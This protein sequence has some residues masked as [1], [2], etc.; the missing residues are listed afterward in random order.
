LQQSIQMKNETEKQ[1]LKKT[2]KPEKQYHF[3]NKVANISSI[4][5]TKKTA[6]NEILERIMNTYLSFPII[7]LP[8]K[9]ILKNCLVCQLHSNLKPTFL[10]TCNISSDVNQIQKLSLKVHIRT[11]NTHMN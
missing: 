6:S 7:V 2:L 4:V 1:S 5:K 11:K 8:L 3:E 10:Q 9:N